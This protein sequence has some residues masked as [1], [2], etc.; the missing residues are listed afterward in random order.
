MKD[1][2]KFIFESSILSDQFAKVLWVVM[3][4]KKEDGKK[5]LDFYNALKDYANKHNWNSV[6]V[7]LNNN[8]KEFYEYEGEWSLRTLKKYATIDQKLYDQYKDELLNKNAKI[9]H[10]YED[11]EIY[12]TDKC[13]FINDETMND[14]IIII[15]C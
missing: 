2:R 9:I 7:L 12:G 6:K 10:K 13:M 8:L 5:E 11:M 3:Y 15:P 1:I 4:I 14:Q